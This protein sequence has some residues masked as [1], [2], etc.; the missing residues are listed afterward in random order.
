MKIREFRQNHEF[1]SAFKKLNLELCRLKFSD[2]L[3]YLTPGLIKKRN[4][5][6]IINCQTIHE[7]GYLE[8]LKN[9]P[10]I[11]DYTLW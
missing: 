4:K 2:P 8:K 5:A 9:V 10:E 3:I 11:V 7:I 6:V 1:N